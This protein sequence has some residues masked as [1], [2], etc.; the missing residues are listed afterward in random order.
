MTNTMSLK[1]Y[2]KCIFC[3]KQLKNSALVKLCTVK[4]DVNDN[5]HTTNTINT[6]NM[7]NIMNVDN[8]KNICDGCFDKNKFVGLTNEMICDIGIINTIKL[9]I[10]ISSK[11][12]FVDKKEWKTYFKLN[13]LS[14][15]KTERKQQLIEKMSSYKLSYSKYEKNQICESY[16]NSGNPDLD[17]VIQR[18]Y[19]KQSEEDDRLCILLEKLKSLN[20]EYN[21]IVPSYK[22]FITKGG[23]INAIIDFAE[24]EKDLIANTNYLSIYETT[25]SDTAKEIVIGK[26]EKKTKTLEKYIAKKNTIKFD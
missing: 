11:Q 5:L 23:D 24:I 1:T 19:L 10:F 7:A 17:T 18:L 3:N 21:C 25:D 14:K 15:Q 4:S 20:L 26:V 8:V 16:V 6:T 2:S 9:Q 13:N 22:K 12:L